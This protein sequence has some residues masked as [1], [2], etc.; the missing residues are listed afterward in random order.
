MKAIPYL[1]FVGACAEGLDFYRGAI[2]AEI[3]TLVRYRDMPGAKADV[4]DRVMHAEFSVGE[5]IIYASDRNGSERHGGEYAISLQAANDVE[6]ERLFGALG[7][8]GRIDVPLMTTPFASRFGMLTDRY[9]T[10][11]IVTTPQT[12]LG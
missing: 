1:F 12:T 10:P 3:R 7:A 8:G 11:W 2:G 5:S 9:G 4:G 6:A